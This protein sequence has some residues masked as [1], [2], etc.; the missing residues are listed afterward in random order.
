MRPAPSVTSSPISAFVETDS[1]PAGS[2][3]LGDAC[4]PFAP[5]P[6]PSPAPA[7]MSPTSPGAAVAPT[8]WL[9]VVVPPSWPHAV[10]SAST[11]AALTTSEALRQEVFIVNP[12]SSRRCW[13]G[14]RA[15]ARHWVRTGE[16]VVFNGGV[17][18]FSAVD[19]PRTP[20][21]RPYTD[22]NP[23]G[24]GSAPVKPPTAPCPSFGPIVR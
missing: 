11:A 19:A 12:R 9:P 20:G 17:F 23:A 7:P 8:F 13:D 5:V 3:A 1:L 22:T 6:R 2:A 14:S 4:A 15:A 10:V 16:P 24:G 18:F 21:R